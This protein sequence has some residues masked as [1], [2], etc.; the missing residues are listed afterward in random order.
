MCDPYNRSMVCCQQC[1]F[2]DFFDEKTAA[3]ELK[4]YRTKGPIKSTRLLIDLLIAEGVRDASLL[5]VGGGIGAIQHELL[6]A[7]AASSVDVDGSE[8]YLAA[9]S[10]ELPEAW[11][12]DRFARIA[13]HIQPRLNTLQDA[14]G[15]VDFLFWPEGPTAEPIDYDEASWAKATK[16]E[17]AGRLLDDVIA[18]Y[19]ALDRWET[20][21]L[22]STMEDL[23]GRYEIKLGPA[24][25]LSRVAVTGRSVGPPLFE[26]LDV[27]GR[28]ET[29]RR[30]EDA[31]RKLAEDAAAGVATDA[32]T[33]AATVDLGA[34][35]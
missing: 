27:L 7:G 2:D 31:S 35:G 12:R 14:P 10:A 24:Q 19:S 11:D 17:W 21:V 18:A 16:P 23:M 34:P 4:R 1:G 33:D 6:D 13:P 29:V 5:D 9:A 30:L 28:D 25:A 32:A 20:A 3:K 8:A 15:V 26:A 22:K